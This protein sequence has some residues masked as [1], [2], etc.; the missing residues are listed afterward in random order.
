VNAVIYTLDPRGVAGTMTVVDQV[1]PTE[2]RTH[3]SK[4]QSSLRTL[5]EAT[6]GFAVVNDNEFD[7]ALKRIDAETSDYYILG[8]YASNA[9]PNRRNRAVEVKT[10]RAGVQIWSR[11]WYRTRAGQTPSSPKH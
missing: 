10:Q 9:D 2:M 8:Y 7:G 6:G 3:I 4:T 5:A 1:D 11:G